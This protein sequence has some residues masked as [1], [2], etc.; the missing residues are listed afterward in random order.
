MTHVLVELSQG[1]IFF[2]DLSPDPLPSIAVTSRGGSG[3]PVEVA[4]PASS[5]SLNGCCVVSVII[6]WHG[7]STLPEHWCIMEHG[8]TI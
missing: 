5:F 6:E 3:R 4:T 8:P 7:M 2:V 1:E